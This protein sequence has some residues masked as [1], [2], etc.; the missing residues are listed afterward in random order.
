MKRLLFL[1]A[2]PCL[3]VSSEEPTDKKSGLTNGHKA[4]WVPVCAGSW[5]YAGYLGATHGPKIAVKVSTGDY[6]GAGI[7]SGKFL[8]NFGQLMGGI[9]TAKR[10]IQPPPT[11]TPLEIAAERS[12]MLTKMEE[13]KAGMEFRQCL[14]THARCR[15]LNGHGVPKRCNSPMRRYAMINQLAAK[16]QMELFKQYNQ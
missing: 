2:L 13:E 5:A 11:Q 7:E 8:W 15:D 3:L 14:N 12:E 10:V 1:L 6:L 4:A 9:C 16:Q